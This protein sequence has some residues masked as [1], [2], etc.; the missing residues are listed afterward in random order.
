MKAEAPA[1]TTCIRRNWKSAVLALALFGVAFGYVEAAVVVY[2]RDL[3]EPVRV[4]YYPASTS[5]DLFP[6]MTPVELHR[7][8][9]GQL[10]QL[11]RVEIPREA[12][13][14]A[15]LAAVAFLVG[16][17][18]MQRVAAFAVAF[19]T[20]DLAFYAFLRILIGW[21]ASLFTWDLLF[22][23]PVPWSGPILAP[24]FVSCS[25]IAAGGIVLREE[26]R[27]RSVR[28]SALSWTGIA[29]G[30]L[31]VLA[32]FTWDYRTVMAG[33]MPH[34][35]EWV[36][37]GLGEAIGLGTFVR[38]LKTQRSDKATSASASVSV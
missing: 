33:R 11:L 28:L 8:N 32:S 7:A 6:V 4:S 29:L 22:L 9:R 20:W 18:P 24:V 27:G 31:T 34:P 13:T 16:T 30:A 37:F 35:F 19:G 2:L 38:A 1:S 3:S 17:N 26:A 14:L 12:A 15:M 21:P 36:V 10:W 25:M 5:A 23:V